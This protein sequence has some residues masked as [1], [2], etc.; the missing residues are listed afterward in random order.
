MSNPQSTWPVTQPLA[1][2]TP[3]AGGGSVIFLL[4]P[5]SGATSGGEQIVHVVN[6]PPPL[7]ALYARFGDNAGETHMLKALDARLITV[8]SLTML[9][10]SLV[11]SLPPATQPGTVEVTL[12][13]TPALGAPTYAKSP[14]RFKYESDTKQAFVITCL[15]STIN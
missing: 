3:A 9:L 13:R 15:D 11:C 6:P 4:S 14:V 12:L 7:A 5:S 10:A 2:D 8:F 1:S